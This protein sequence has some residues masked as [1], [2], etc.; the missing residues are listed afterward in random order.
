ML[1]LRLVI[2]TN[3]LVSAALKLEGLRAR[4]LIL[5]TTK[6][7]RLYVSQPILDEYADVLAR[8]ELRICKGLRLQ[9]LS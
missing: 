2:E 8:P 4:P 6:A 3:V 9:L 1:P 7:A 5:A